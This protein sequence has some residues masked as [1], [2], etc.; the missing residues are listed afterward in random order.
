[1][2]GLVALLGGVRATVFAGIAL[3]LLAV[4]AV[5]AMRLDRRADQVDTLEVQAALWQQAVTSKDQAISDL[6]LA[7]EEWKGLAEQRKQAAAAAVES[8]A[9]ERDALA[10]EL[11]NRR[12]DRGQ[13]YAQ[14]P[15][16]A[17]WGRTR[18][19]ARIADQLRK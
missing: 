15:D 10:A 7:N 6:K 18:I 1:M 3:V 8:V 4:C 16:A 11:A 13:I 5:Q 19:P 14:D 9:R 17:A 2:N 12:R